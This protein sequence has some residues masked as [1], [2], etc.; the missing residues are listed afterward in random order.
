MGLLPKIPTKPPPKWSLQ[1]DK[2]LLSEFM[3]E[4]ISIVPLVLLN[5]KILNTVMMPL[6]ISWHI[7][8]LE[9]PMSKRHPKLLRCLNHF[10]FQG[11]FRPNS[12]V[13][14]SMKGL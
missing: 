9:N 7:L 12:V 3:P 4:N 11:K 1:E 13:R 14:G 6:K 8:L 10:S 5:D 2:T